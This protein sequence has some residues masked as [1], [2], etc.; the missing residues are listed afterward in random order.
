ML[1]REFE[2]SESA[3]IRNEPATARGR[4]TRQTILDAAESVFGECPYE[5][6]SISEITRRAGVAQGAFY[7]YF[8]NKKAAFIELIHVLNH[9]MRRS[10]AE[11]I[12]GLDD[13]LEV[14]RAGFKAFFEYIAQH[15]GLYRM[16]RESEFVDPE[17]HRWHYETIAK[18]YVAGLEKAQGSGQVCH[19]I[20]AETMAWTLM[21]AGE[22][23]GARFVVWQGEPLPDSVIDE[24]G[25]LAARAVR[26][27]EY[28]GTKSG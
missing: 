6:S 2:S 7:L 20:S 8:P 22:L 1:E 17:T 19:D 16:V 21:G 9:N 24:V 12:E 28:P 23:I 18:S 5:K 10:M 11:A 14:E 25:E 3:V 13:R 15:R 26:P 4:A 27:V